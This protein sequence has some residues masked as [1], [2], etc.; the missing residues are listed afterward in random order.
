MDQDSESR[1]RLSGFNSLYLFNWKNFTEVKIGLGQTNYLVGPNAV[2]KSNFLDAFRFVRDISV[3]GLSQAVRSRGGMKS[4][5]SINARNDPSVTMEFSMSE[6]NGT[7]W[8]YRLSFTGKAEVQVLHESATMDGQEIL[9]RPSVEDEDAYSRSQTHIQQ[10]G[11]NKSVRPIVDLFKNI[12]YMHPVPQL[13]REVERGRGS[14]ADAYGGNMIERM[15][16]LPARSRDARLGRIAKSLHEALPNLKDI[17]VVIDEASG[18]PHLRFK[19]ENWRPRGAWQTEAS[20]SDGTLRLVGLLWTLQEGGGPLL[21]E[22]PE[23][24]LHPELVRRL[25][26]IFARIQRGASRQVLVSTHS[27]EMLSENVEAGEI[28]LFQPTSEGTTIQRL[29]EDVQLMRQLGAGRPLPD[30]AS[31]RS[32]PRITRVSDLLGFVK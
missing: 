28:L 12:T 21:L 32:G 6:V 3:D 14:K 25:P 10:A 5:R 22:E 17:K 23:L 27:P 15:A 1:I 16:H 7:E 31:D 13:M 26:L 4:I 2:G 19:F 20:L 9:G 8:T 29:S 24:S 18:T 11:M 30:I